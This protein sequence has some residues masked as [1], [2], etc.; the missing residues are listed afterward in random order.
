MTMQHDNNA[1]SAPLFIELRPG[2]RKALAEAG[3]P[4]IGNDLVGQTAFVMGECDR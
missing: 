4:D 1:A 3:L 2:M